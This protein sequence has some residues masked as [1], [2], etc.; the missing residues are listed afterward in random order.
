MDTGELITRWTIRVALLLY[1]LGTAARSFPHARMNA[2]PMNTAKALWSLGAVCY[3]AHV[4]AAFHVYHHWSHAEAFE[5]IATETERMI[6]T[7]FGHG[8]YFN[9][10]FGIVWIVDTI[11][12]LR[13]TPGSS[14][15]R[16]MTATTHA[17]LLFIVFNGL[18]VFKDGGLRWFGI[19]G[20]VFVL[21]A[22]TLGWRLRQRRP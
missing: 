9:H 16:W 21:A 1:F 12:W 4:A 6:H 15:R 5:H 20:T 2:K 22:W 18:V 19:G 11:R 13:E 10:A 3:L 7:R 14:S 8:I 17:F